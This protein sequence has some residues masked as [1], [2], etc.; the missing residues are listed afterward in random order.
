M[1]GSRGYAGEKGEDDLTEDDRRCETTV[2]PKASS[3]GDGLP[4]MRRI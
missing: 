2:S 1:A 3:K 4:Q